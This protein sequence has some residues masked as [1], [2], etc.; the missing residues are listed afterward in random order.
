MCEVMLREVKRFVRCFR[1]RI[2]Q[3]TE[4]AAKKMVI[5]SSETFSNSLNSFQNPMW[6]SYCFHGCQGARPESHVFF[7]PP[8]LS[9]YPKGACQEHSM[10]RNLRASSREHEGPPAPACQRGQL[11]T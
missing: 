1:I 5:R 9:W 10:L 11:I 2:S 7:K 8:P 4:L 6:L 3:P